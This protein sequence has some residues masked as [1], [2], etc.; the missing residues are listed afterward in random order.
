MKNWIKG[1]YSV[2]VLENKKIMFTWILQAKASEIGSKITNKDF[3][4][5]KRLGDFGASVVYKDG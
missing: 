5:S 1:V 4:C 2:V 3:T